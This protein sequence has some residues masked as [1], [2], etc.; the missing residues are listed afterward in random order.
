MECIRKSKQLLVLNGTV[1]INGKFE[2]KD[3][4]IVD[5]K[6]AELAEPGKL[7]HEMTV[8]SVKNSEREEVLDAAGKYI[9]P[10]LVDIHTHGRIGEDFSFSSVES[11]RKLLVSYAA[12]GVTSVVGTTMTNEPEPVENSL[13]AMGEYIRA[14][15]NAAGKYAEDSQLPCAKL[16]GIHMEGPF[17]GTEKKGAHDARFLRTPDWN[18]FKKMQKLSSESIRLV[19]I[20][21]TLEGSEEFIKKCRENNS[22]V[23]IGH[24]SCDYE[25]AIRAGRA[26][27]D[28][29]THL[30]N[31]MSPLHHREPGLIGAAMDNGMYMELICDGIHVHPAVVRMM[32][33]AYPEQMVLISD[34]ISAAGMPEGEYASG[35][36]KICVKD[37]KVTLEDGTIAGS[38]ISLYDAMVNAIRFGVPAEAAINSATYLPAKSVG[39]E[40]VAGSIAVGRTADFLVVD[41]EWRLV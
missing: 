13:R 1:F 6:F 3:I 31:A 26:G 34:S 8:M 23:S 12:C 15:G 39:M 37:G 16:L 28:H 14:Q 5:G 36:M 40:Q 20:D 7:G 38:A 9:L 21:P 10:G 24:T 35:G 17:L 33:A 25:A 18:W 2:K 19:T 27:A 29:V 4:R 22:K 41:K 32:F 30:F 11:L